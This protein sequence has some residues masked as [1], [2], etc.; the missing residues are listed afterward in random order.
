M[1]CDI[2]HGVGITHDGNLCP[3]CC[4]EELTI[5]R[6]TRQAAAAAVLL[7]GAALY[8]AFTLCR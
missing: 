1:Q 3:A 6:Q 8:L 5:I 4:Q 2:C 7:I